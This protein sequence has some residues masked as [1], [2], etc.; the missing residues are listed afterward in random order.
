MSD[1]PIGTSAIDDNRAV[2]SVIGVVILF[3]FLILALSLYQVEVVPQQN[4]EAEF[5]HSGEVRND[6]VELR[7]GILQAGSIDQPQYQTVQLGTA[8]S[9][10]TFTINPPSPAGTI[11]TTDPYPITIS[12]KSGTS[13]GTVTIPTRF[14]EYQP[15]YNELDR[16]PTWY[17]ASVLYLDARDKGGRI[18]VIEDQTLFDDGEVQITALQNEFRRSGTDQVTLELRPAE[19]VSGEIPEGDLNVTVPTRLNNSE[20]WNETDIPNNKYSVSDPDDDNVYNLTLET[21]ASN[22]TVNTVGVQKAPEDPTQNDAVRVGGNGGTEKDDSD[23][24]VGGVPDGPF[25]YADP[26]DDLEYE[27]GDPTY[28][29][30]ELY[31]FDENVNL[32]IPSDVGGGEIS[33]GKISI[34]ADKITSRVDYTTNNNGVT[35]NTKNAGPIDIT[36]ASI[37]SE[38]STTLKKSTRATLDDATI[39]RTGK[40][41]VTAD[42]ISARNTD[43]TT[44][45]NGVT[46]NTKNAGPIDIT[47]ASIDSEGSTTLKKST[48]ATLDDATITRTGKLKVTADEIS[49]R[50]ADIT[51][52]NNGVTFNT[53]N[54]GPIDITGASIDSE[55][56]TT[57][58][59][60]TR[61]TLDDATI[62]RTG[63]LKITADEISVRNADITTNNNGVTFTAG[64]IS[65][66]NT[67]ITT[68]N[69]GV[70]L[71]A[72][73]S[74]VRASG[75][76]IDA[77]GK[78]NL[79][80]SGDIRIDD[81]T[82][83]ESRI[84]ASGVA[85]AEFDQGSRTFFVDGVEISDNDNE[86]NYSPDGVSVD[87][88]PDDGTV[89]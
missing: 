55:G 88:D 87:G 15:G 52:N 51:T 26:N 27:E 44:N 1:Y 29:E 67:D 32:V 53:K 59:K 64:E 43:I 49:V 17:D 58:K 42:E 77:V 5:Q 83:Q 24:S 3:G 56:S 45:N 76:Q 31:K 47:G 6:L 89:G 25:A 40:L 21:T 54:A 72:E 48:R 75:I 14:I 4:T 85:T 70:T 80:A 35:F 86:L 34:T 60:S 81:S 39:T 74:G 10:R 38:G 37:D 7:A 18:A 69:N 63:K 16:S 36:G 71:D 22:L 28:K 57:L 65:A 8:Y 9:P 82:E 66:R 79:D 68:N 84:D 13:E 23:D 50:N 61:A 46:F 73:E 2:S 20:Y 41:K 62:T 33:N 11:R 12:N 19:D 30:S 78:V